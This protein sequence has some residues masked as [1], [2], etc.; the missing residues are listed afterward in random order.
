MPE[1]HEISHFLN[2]FV[3]GLLEG[4]VDG[5]RDGVV[6]NFKMKWD[7]ELDPNKVRVI[8]ETISNP[9][10]RCL[11]IHVDHDGQHYESVIRNINYLDD[12]RSP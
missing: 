1:R 11:S 12:D 4:T 8:L 9:E 10:R 2:K 5:V 6:R 3:L 7:I